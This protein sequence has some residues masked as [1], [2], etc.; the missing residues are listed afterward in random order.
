MFIFQTVYKK[1]IISASV[2]GRECLAQRPVTADVG[3]AHPQGQG[4]PFR[5]PR[6][7]HSKK[8]G[9]GRSRSACAFWGRGLRTNL[10]S[11]F[12]DRKICGRKQLFESS[13]NLT[14][15]RS[16]EPVREFPAV[17]LGMFADD[18][19]SRTQVQAAALPLLSIE[20]FL[21]PGPSG[22]NHSPKDVHILSPRTLTWQKGLCR[23][24]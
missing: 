19:A 13:R 7:L 21:L 23:W 10:L 15:F 6:D 2:T 11:K 4:L 3:L 16:M 18:N 20:S 17:Y 12:S 1:C 24:H 5:D 9:Q 8:L 14:V 22:H